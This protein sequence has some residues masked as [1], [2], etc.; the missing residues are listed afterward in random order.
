M[1]PNDLRILSWRTFKLTVICIIA[2]AIMAVGMPAN[3]S[4]K[5]Y[6]DPVHIWLVR[7]QL[8]ALGTSQ[9]TNL[10]SLASGAIA[11]RKGAKH[12][13]WIIFSAILLLIFMAVLFV[14]ILPKVG[15]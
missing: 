10:I 8:L 11:W 13:A 7:L 3:P 6:G 9:V 12:C 15:L 2:G 1:A 14:L 4:F 5:G